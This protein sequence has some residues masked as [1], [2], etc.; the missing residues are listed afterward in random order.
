MLCPMMPYLGYAVFC[1]AMC[2]DIIL[3]LNSGSFSAPESWT[4]ARTSYVRPHHKWLLAQG[5][6][7][8]ETSEREVIRIYYQR[9]KPRTAASTIER[10]AIRRYYQ[11]IK[12][13]RA[14]PTSE[15][16]LVLHTILA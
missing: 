5:P 15:R 9:I 16:P 11:R 2:C 3:S 1:D 13:R 4:G 12:P 8:N 7:S 14:A 10:E 6:T